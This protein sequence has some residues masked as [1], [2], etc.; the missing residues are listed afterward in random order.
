MQFR[1]GVG[2]WQDWASATIN[3]ASGPTHHFSPLP[4]PLLLIK[5]EERKIH[6]RTLII[7]QELLSSE[8]S[9]FGEQ[10]KPREKMCSILVL[11][12]T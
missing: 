1:A 8:V 2:D 4:F 12:Y 3:I 5:W 6:S 10:K 7:S 9:Q 11:T